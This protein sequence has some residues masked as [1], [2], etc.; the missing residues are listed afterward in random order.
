M[1]RSLF[2]WL[3]V[4]NVVLALAL[5]TVVVSQKKTVARVNE[6][7]MKTLTDSNDQHTD[8]VRHMLGFV[9]S[10][11]SKTTNVAFLAAAWLAANAVVSWRCSGRQHRV[12]ETEPTIPAK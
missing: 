3:A 12:G 2:K 5:T 4:V 1:G 7:T 8:F 10:E 11:T 6:N 9:N